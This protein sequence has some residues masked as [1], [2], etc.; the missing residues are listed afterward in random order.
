[1]S[2]NS[3]IL[4]GLKL[5]NI[6]IEKLYNQLSYKLNLSSLQIK[7]ILTIY[8]SPHKINLSTL[9][10]HIGVKVS[11]I[12]RAIE[13]LRKK[14][15]IALTYEGKSKIITSTEKIELIVNEIESHLKK[16]EQVL[17]SLPQKTKANILQTFAK[18]IEASYYKKYIIFSQSC[19]FCS[20]FKDIDQKTFF[21]K[22]INKKLKKE[23]LKIN[24]K[25]FNSANS[26]Q[27]IC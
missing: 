11:T 5:I 12:S 17:E 22:F 3:Q 7:I 26:Y 23:N 19:I 6:I 10:K 18:L 9:A 21:C 24:C 4:E 16:Y 25:D 14:E 15:I 2:I 27:K 13:N 20:F 1:M 8:Y